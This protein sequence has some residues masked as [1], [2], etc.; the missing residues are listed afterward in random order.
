M[1]QIISIR[2]KCMSAKQNA[3]FIIKPP[4]EL[5]ADGPSHQRRCVVPLV[6]LA[7]S[8][9]L[10]LPQVVAS[11]LHAILGSLLRDT[12]THPP[13]SFVVGRNSGNIGGEI[14]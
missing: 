13:Q 5:R 7:L 2:L 9:N 14:L 8:V 1:Q 10:I 4:P 11:D 6:W 3:V 12:H